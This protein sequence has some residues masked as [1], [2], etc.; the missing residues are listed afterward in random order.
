MLAASFG[1]ASVNVARVKVADE[2]ATAVS[3][4]PPIA[5]RAAAA[6]V[7]VLVVLDWAPLL[8]VRATPTENV[9]A[10]S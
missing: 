2:L 8:S 9:P 3:E 1:L 5:V 4:K 7:A 10:W 6:T